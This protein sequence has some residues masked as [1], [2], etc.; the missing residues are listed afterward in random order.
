V[1][2]YPNFEFNFIKI[3]EYWQS[4][5]DYETA[6]D[7][8]DKIEGQYGF[9]RAQWRRKDPNDLV[10]G[11]TSMASELEEDIYKCIAEAFA[12]DD[13]S[14]YYVS[15]LTHDQ[16]IWA[17]S[18]IGRLLEEKYGGARLFVC[19]TWRNESDRYQVDAGRTLDEVIRHNLD[20][21]RSLL[22][23]RRD[24]DELPV[25]G[26]G[27]QRKQAPRRYKRDRSRLT[28]EQFKRLIKALQV[29]GWTDCKWEEA[30]GIWDDQFSGADDYCGDRRL[31]WKG[32]FVQYRAFFDACVE[33]PLEPEDR[34]FFTDLGI[35][36]FFAAHFSYY[37][38][39]VLP[40]RAQNGARPPSD[41][42][43]S[44]ALKI[45]RGIRRILEKRPGSGTANPG[46]K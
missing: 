22:D 24:T 31:N 9:E 7:Y 44:Q 27:D 46:G 42:T 10:K 21:E 40:H 1:N 15:S 38:E 43:K 45:V 13:V 3:R 11:Y 4:L 30:Q 35:G 8:L 23:Y 26:N 36:E 28:S 5:P 16:H 14:D 2:R 19:V 25:R 17:T 18:K 41:E 39:E 6:K 37:G 32:S 29:E 34:L 12:K 33:K 20:E